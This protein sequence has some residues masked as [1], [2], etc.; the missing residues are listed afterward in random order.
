MRK[1]CGVW[2]RWRHRQLRRLDMEFLVPAFESA[3][4]AYPVERVPEL[5]EWAWDLH[6]RLP[7]Q[8]HWRCPCALEE[9]KT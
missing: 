7:G 6:K 3:A 8:G 4:E 2:I 9:I 1:R 5:M